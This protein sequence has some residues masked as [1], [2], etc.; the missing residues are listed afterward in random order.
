MSSPGQRVSKMF[1]RSASPRTLYGDDSDGNGR[2]HDR[3]SR[4][5]CRGHSPG[6]NPGHGR[7]GARI[8]SLGVVEV[9]A[10]V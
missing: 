5:L 7:G 2:C 1:P 9:L 10:R 3:G 6:H 4:S 8:F